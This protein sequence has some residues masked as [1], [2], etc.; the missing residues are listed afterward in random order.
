VDWH[1]DLVILGNSLA[2]IKGAIHA[3]TNRRVGLVITDTAELEFDFLSQA[4]TAIPPP[5][6]RYEKG[7]WLQGEIRRLQQVYS[8]AALAQAGVDVILGSGVWQKRS[9]KKKLEFVLNGDC[10]QSH[11]FLLIDR[12][13]VIN[14][15]GTEKSVLEILADLTTATKIPREQRQL[16]I[17]SGQSLR[18]LV[19]V[20]V[21]LELG[22]PVAW[23]GNLAQLLAAEDP[24]VLQGLTADLAQ[25]RVT[26]IDLVPESL[27]TGSVILG[28]VTVPVEKT[29]MGLDALNIFS[30]PNTIDVNPYLQTRQSQLWACG[31]WLAGYN[32]AMI[33]QAEVQ[34]LLSQSRSRWPPKPMTYTTVPW[35]IV[36]PVPIGRVGWHLQAAQRV[37]KSQIITLPVQ[38]EIGRGCGQ[39][40]IDQRQQ[41]LGA[42]L[43]GHSAISAVKTLG[44]GMAG[45][46]L[47]ACLAAAGWQVVVHPRQASPSMIGFQ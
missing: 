2:V 25:A 6:N 13:S 18:E 5:L 36:A 1:Y 26:Q 14:Y 21:C 3:A 15:R 10:L 38:P 47:G 23:G 12:P 8:L 45:Q 37:F 11:R 24:L 32:V 35:G 43:W 16:V 17:I 27:P 44:L 30:K 41:L 7:L 46:S 4:L 40:V 34:Y 28:T 20:Q 33:T 22:I 31:S 29:L 39:I 42:T 19:W 9:N